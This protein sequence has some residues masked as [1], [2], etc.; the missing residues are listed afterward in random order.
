MI[1]PNFERNH[2][3]LILFPI[4]HTHNISV[5]AFEESCACLPLLSRPPPRCPPPLLLKL[6]LLSPPLSLLPRKEY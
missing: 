2:H 1:T 6:L 5:I 3:L 4:P